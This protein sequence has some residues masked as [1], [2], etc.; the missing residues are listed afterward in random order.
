[1]RILN[2]GSLNID[3]VCHVHQIVRAGQTI[4]AYQA[5]SQPGGK[6][7]NQSLAAARAGAEVYHA[8]CVGDDGL[9]LRHIL[10]DS[11]VECS[12]IRLTDEQTGSAFIQV[13]DEGQNCIVVSGGANKAIPNELCEHL[14]EI[15][16]DQTILLLQNEIN[17]TPYL[18]NLAYQK[19]LYIVLNPSPA[20]D[21][22][23][24]CDLDKVNMLIVNEE[25][26]QY[27]TGLPKDQMLSGLCAQYPKAEIVLTLGAKG[28]V[29]RKGDQTVFQPAVPT[30]VVDTTAAGDT[31]TGYL[32]ASL[33][34]KQPIQTA[35]QRAALAASIAVSRPGAADSIPYKKELEKAGV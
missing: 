7:L 33:C 21:S 23:Q 4:C 16:D 3:H 27:L 24:A 9:F 25:E 11:G 5:H 10:F 15:F 20:D 8:G 12:N 17:Q 22:L 13:D 18:I 30:D 32:L 28:A 26:G 6:G 19:G 1:M 31:F 34:R 29:Y 2:F 14:L 35:M